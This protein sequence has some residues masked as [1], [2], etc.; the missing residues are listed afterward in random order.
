[1]RDIIGAPERLLEIFGLVGAGASLAPGLRQ[2]LSGVFTAA[3]SG[4][5]PRGPVTASCR[6]AFAMISAARRPGREEI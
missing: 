4:P 2:G 3:P 1:M 5:R 6:A